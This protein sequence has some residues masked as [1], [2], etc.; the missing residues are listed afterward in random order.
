MK[1]ECQ[2]KPEVM[3]PTESQ[4]K[5]TILKL[6]SY[7]P[8]SFASLTD[9]VGNYIQVAGG[10]VTCMVEKYEVSGDNRMRAFHD[11]PSP[12]FPDGTVLVFGGGELKMKADEWFLSDMV[13]E[14]FLCFFH[15]REYPENV[16]W[17]KAPG[18]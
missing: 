13:V 16:G 18:F 4:I 12:V 6:R 14:L 11:K 3:N 2:G 7:G 10:G 8:C 17:R 1:L 5:K 15:K 9:D